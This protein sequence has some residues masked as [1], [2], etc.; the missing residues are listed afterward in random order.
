VTTLRKNK[1]E[2]ENENL[3]TK[4]TI[5]NYRYLKIILDS[6]KS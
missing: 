3:A 5:K 4:E 1:E 2:D 6:S